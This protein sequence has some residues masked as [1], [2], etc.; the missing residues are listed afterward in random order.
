MLMKGNEVRVMVAALD[1]TTPTDLNRGV[2]V[3]GR[4]DAP[5]AS[6]LG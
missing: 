4:V 5:E 3:W 6:E 2:D 1:R